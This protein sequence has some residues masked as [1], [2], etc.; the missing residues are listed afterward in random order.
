MQKMHVV[1]IFVAALIL[2]SPS[3]ATTAEVF[4]ENNRTY[5]YTRFYS[6]QEEA[7]NAAVAAYTRVN[8]IDAGF[9]APTIGFIHALMNGGVDGEGFQDAGGNCVAMF[10]VSLSSSLALVFATG[11]TP[12]SARTK[13][14]NDCVAGNPE[15]NIFPEE[16]S[17]RQGLNN[18]IQVCA[19]DPNNGPETHMFHVAINGVRSG[20]GGDSNL[21]GI[22][23]AGV[24][25]GVLAAL[26]YFA[27][28]DNVQRRFTPQTSFAF[29]N[30][31]H[32]HTLGGRWDYWLG[33]WSGYSQF[34]HANFG[35]EWV[36][37]SGI[38][39][40]HRNL[41]VAYDSVSDG[42]KSEMEI[43]LS[44]T[45]ARWQFY[46]GYNLEKTISDATN[47]FNIGTRYGMDK[48]ILSANGNTDGNHAA[49]TINYSYRF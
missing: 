26:I 24:G 49:A 1:G 5:V 15:N 34:V 10:P 9:T 23:Y 27:T 14:V 35:G 11:D 19:D 22:L 47:R 42:K 4:A 8:N 32:T 48:W 2:S 16:E 41:S 12:E 20:G 3:R 29:N 18:A 44:A 36:A 7:N 45:A 17:C 37:A 40:H 39:W 38:Q 43:S 30:G 33:Q 6:S 28:N 25:V 46:G 21:Q 31:F 13:A